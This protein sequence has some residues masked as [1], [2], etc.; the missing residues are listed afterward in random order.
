M[1]NFLEYSPNKSPNLETYP[2]A[3]LHRKKLSGKLL[4]MMFLAGMTV[5]T[6]CSSSK[7]GGT[8]GKKPAWVKERP[9]NSD[10]YIGIGMA[11][12][13]Q[14][15]Y[16]KIAKKNALTDLV[17]E[18]SVEI[19]GSSVLHQVEDEGGFRQKYESFTRT[20]LQEQL[21]GYEV[22]DSYTG[23]K[24]HWVYY[25]LSKAKYQR[26][27]REKLERARA[28]AR[29]FYQKA[30]DARANRN[31]HEALN[32]YGKAFAAIRTFLDQDLSVMTDQG[33]V[34]LGLALYREIQETLNAIAV[35][36]DQEPFR[37]KPFSKGQKA[38]SATVFYRDDQGKHRVTDLPFR[39]Y[40]A[41]A[42]SSSNHQVQSNQSGKITCSLA[43]MPFTGDQNRI[44]VELNTG[45][46]FDSKDS[47]NNLLG[48][49]FKTQGSVPTGYINI[50]IDALQAYFTSSEEKFGKPA[51]AHPVANLFKEVLT[52][53]AFALVS[54]P[55]QAD[56]II[57]IEANTTKGKLIDRYDLYTAY[58]NCNVSL[59]RAGDQT[60][61]YS[62]GLQNIKGMKAG[63]YN[64]AARDARKKAKDQIRQK[65]LPE[66]Q[67]LKF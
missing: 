7:I 33:K 47:Q 34:N 30:R 58:L 44:K 22:V 27:K 17:S 9:V 50:K 37:V 29:E 2:T 6:S 11:P 40:L 10:Y 53:N 12:T 46:Y 41:E 51:Q 56:V 65:I 59:I 19:S 60:E 39:C 5:L 16:M 26:M 25:R 57:K 24:H 18:I 49:L 42:N 8:G 61:I 43:G 13:N 20:S 3:R 28:T 52:R 55:S 38:V 23:R 62:T 21:E 54:N 66:L 32:Y 4:L 14:A 1:V 31:I 63:G 67:A 36:P 45:V 64:M 35:V 48:R 15:Q